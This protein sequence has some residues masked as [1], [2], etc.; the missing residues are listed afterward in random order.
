MRAKE[1]GFGADFG[2]GPFESAKEYF[3]S[4]A[5]AYEKLA[6]AVV[7]EGSDW[8]EASPVNCAGRLSFS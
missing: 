8:A 2:L 4:Q 6:I 5:E 7:A 1:V 3:A